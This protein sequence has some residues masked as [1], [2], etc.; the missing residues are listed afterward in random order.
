MKA[1]RAITLHCQHCGAVLDDW[2]DAD[3]TMTP[4]E[5]S[6][7]GPGWQDNQPERREAAV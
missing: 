7:E 2:Q 6:K 1:K 4:V 5:L 3:R